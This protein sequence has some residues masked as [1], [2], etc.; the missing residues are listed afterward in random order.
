MG[1]VTKKKKIKNKNTGIVL[2]HLKKSTWSV[3]V[4]CVCVQKSDCFHY[5]L[6]CFVVVFVV[7]QLSSFESS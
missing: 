3:V 7:V 4:R 6:L 5:Y 2:M 1:T